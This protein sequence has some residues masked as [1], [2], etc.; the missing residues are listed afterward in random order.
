MNRRNFLQLCTLNAIGFSAIGLGNSHAAGKAKKGDRPNIVFI[1]ADDLGFGD[2]KCLNADSKIPTPNLD[3]L[4]TEGM[5]F[6]DAHSGSAVCTPTRYGLLT[7]RYAW[8]SPLKNS[9][10][11][12][13]DPPLIAKDRM[14]VA[15]M[16]KKHD[17]HTA[18]IGKWHLGWDW[19]TTDGSRVGDQVGLGVYGGNI[20]AKIGKKIDLTKPIP[21][22]PTTRGFDYYFG[23]SVPNFTPY[24]FIENDRTVGIPSEQ[25]P[26]SMFGAPGMMLKGWNLRKILPAIESKA[27]EYIEDRAD[28]KEPFF[29]YMPLT[30]PHTP[31]AP[32]KEYQGK[33]KAGA[34]G[35]FV[36]QVDAVAGSVMRAIERTGQA[37]NTLLIFTSD[38]GSPARDGTN[39][40]GALDSVKRFGHN[41]SYIYRGRKAQIWDGGH[42]VPFFVRWPGRVAAGSRCEQLVCLGDFMRT[43]ADVLGERLGDNTAE[44]SVSILPLMMGKVDTPVR[45]SIIHHDYHGQFAIR[46]GK[47]KFVMTGGGHLYDMET[48]PSETKNLFNEKQSIAEKLHAELV[49]SV[50]NG[51][52]TPGTPQ[53][54]DGPID[55]KFSFPVSLDHTGDF[56]VVLNAEVKRHKMGYELS[57]PSIG[58]ALH[59][60]DEPMRK[61]GVF[62]FSCR[63]LKNQAPQNALFV[64]GDSADADSLVKCG[65]MVGAN[66]LAIWKGTWEQWASGDNRKIALESGKDYDVRVEIDMKKQ[67]VRMRTA[68]NELQWPLPQNIKEIQ[69]YGYLVNGTSS[70]FSFAR[71]SSLSVR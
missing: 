28:S 14:T 49:E 56:D 5:T 9:V 53:K 66:Q 12:P 22:G 42:R 62:E 7:G 37:D 51:R 16:L 3:R 35:D 2:V 31:I 60:L 26:A 59:K 63:S 71:Q 44:D 38:N 8:R 18:C 10:L 13:W 57:S 24:C 15:D 33:S 27:V 11:W 67:V 34:Y 52:S 40:D 17:Y 1:L 41:P 58:C 45:E 50:K 30:A 48:D 25:K 43:C 29:L 23:T 19:P 64:F 4:A 69:C 68:G 6:S 46:R 21:G 20:R 47:W 32:S 70:A 36:N 39:M 65:F 61:G 54:N 55:L